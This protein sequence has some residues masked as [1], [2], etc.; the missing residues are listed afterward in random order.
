MTFIVSK[1]D[2]QEEDET[3]ARK[4]KTSNALKNWT[5][6]S[7]KAELIYS[8]ES[9]GNIFLSFKALASFL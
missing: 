6:F 3:R 2:K 8:T 5:I 1:L 9:D 4:K 7:D